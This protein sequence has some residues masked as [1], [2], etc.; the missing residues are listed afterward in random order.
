[1]ELSAQLCQSFGEGMFISGKRYSFVTGYTRKLRGGSQPI[2]VQAD[3]GHLYVVKFNNNLQGSNLPFNESIGSELYRI[4]NLPGPLWEPLVVT[5]AFLDRNPDCWMETE[6]ERLRPNSGVCFG[7]RFLGED[8]LRL[9]EILPGT[10]LKWVRNH[11]DF[12]LAWLIDICAGHVDNRQ[13]IFLESANGELKAFFLDHG[14]LF[15]GPKGELRQHF[16]ASRYL[17]PRIYRNVSSQYL[18]YLQRVVKN[19]EVDRLWNWTHALPEEWKTESALDEFTMCLSRLSTP[20]LVD[21]IL[22]TI[23]CAYERDSGIEQGESQNRR[24]GPVSVLCPGI[25]ATGLERDFSAIGDCG[26]ART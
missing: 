2:L 15:G 13:A 5:D 17:D 11:Q 9:F 23:V 22:E 16:L 14:H 8:G 1:M 4:C 19:L 3:D 25:Q 21:N 26:F 7:S 6:K 12:W 24:Q 20:T 10:S 18:D